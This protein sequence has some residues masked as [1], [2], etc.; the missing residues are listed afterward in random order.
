MIREDIWLC[1]NKPAMLAGSD[2]SFPYNKLTKLG[3]TCHPEVVKMPK[4]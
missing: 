3:L 4:I 2:N 1:N